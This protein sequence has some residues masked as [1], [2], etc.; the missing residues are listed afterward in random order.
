MSLLFKPSSYRAETRFGT[1]I[2]TIYAD[3]GAYAQRAWGYPNVQV[4]VITPDYVSLDEAQNACAA[5]LTQLANSEAQPI[6][7]EEA[8]HAAA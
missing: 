2:I 5:R 1:F 3:G 7:T 4:E 6:T 8:T